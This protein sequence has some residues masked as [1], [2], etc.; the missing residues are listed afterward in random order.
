MISTIHTLV[1]N[2]L[3][4]RGVSESDRPMTGMTLTRGESRRI[5]SMSISLRLRTRNLVSPR[6]EKIGVVETRTRGP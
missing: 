2:A 1:L 5:S 4:S 3:S 6:L